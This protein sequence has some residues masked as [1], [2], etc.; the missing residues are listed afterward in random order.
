[1]MKQWRCRLARGTAPARRFV[2]VLCFAGAWCGAALEA[3]SW[4]GLTYDATAAPIDNPLKGFVNY[5]ALAGLGSLPY[6][7]EYFYVPMDAVMTSSS[8]FDWSYI[9]SRLIDIASRGRQAIFRVYVDFPFAASSPTDCQSASEDPLAF[10]AIP[11]F[12]IDPLL[13]GGDC[14]PLTHYCSDDETLEGF[15]PDY[16]WDSTDGDLEPDLLEAFSALITEMATR[17]DGDARVAFVQVGLLGHWGEWHTYFDGSDG[18]ALMASEATMEAVLQ[19]FDGQ[20]FDT[21][22]LVSADILQ[23]DMNVVQWGTKSIGLHDDAFGDTTVTAPG[24]PPGGGS[25]YDRLLFWGFEQ[26]WEFL[27]IAG[28]VAPDLQ[29]T[30]HDECPPGN[31]LDVAIDTVHASWLLDAYLFEGDGVTPPSN[32]ELACATASA[33]TMGY[34]LYVLEV[35]LSDAQRGGSFELSLRLR[36]AGVAPFY[37]DWPVEIALRRLSDGVVVKSFVPGDWY[38]PDVFAP[39]AGLKDFQFS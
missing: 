10:T 6:S 3:Q 31:D 36:N 14:L 35:L 32:D 2:V 33:R 12:L 22:T 37:Y 30:V 25:F 20:W 26:D 16:E 39:H 13:C 27:P 28:E 24:T 34:Q 19:A 38:L 5:E 29:P 4:T 1:M 8:S 18:A 21:W 15:S 11:H 9:E 17:Y 23:Y 7:L